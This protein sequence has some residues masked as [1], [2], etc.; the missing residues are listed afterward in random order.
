MNFEGFGDIFLNKILVNTISRELRTLF[1]GIQCPFS[2]CQVPVL[3]CQSP[4]FAILDCG[5]GF[6]EYFSFHFCITFISFWHRFFNI[7]PTP[8]FLIF[9]DLG[10]RPIVRII[11]IP[12]GK[13]RLPKERFGARETNN[14]SFWH[15][16]LVTFLV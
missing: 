2:N 14:C 11:E 16:L 3:G 10:T 9:I 6:G 13:Q 4:F 1:S 7:F 5:Y 8:F 15:P 12:K